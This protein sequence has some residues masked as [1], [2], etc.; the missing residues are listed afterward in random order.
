MNHN[1]FRVI[2]GKVEDAKRVCKG[3]KSMKDRQ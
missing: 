2:Q 1:S 3:S